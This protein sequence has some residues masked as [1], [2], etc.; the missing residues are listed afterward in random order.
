MLAQSKLR[1]ES[2]LRECP[3]LGECE[4]EKIKKRRS[5][6]LGRPGSLEKKERLNARENAHALRSTRVESGENG[7]IG[8]AKKGS[9]A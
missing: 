8:G 2:Y 9:S 1:E 5:N 6:A 7:L 4:S 3:L